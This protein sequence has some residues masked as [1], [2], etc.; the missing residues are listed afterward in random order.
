MRI[1]HAPVPIIFCPFSSLRKGILH[2]YDDMSFYQME[3]QTLVLR[4]V[5]IQMGIACFNISCPVKSMA[6]KLKTV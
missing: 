3:V 2:T 5:E 6:P 4:Y 1:S